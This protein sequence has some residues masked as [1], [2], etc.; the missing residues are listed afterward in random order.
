MTFLASARN[1]IHICEAASEEYLGAYVKSLSI[2]QD[3]IA[4]YVH[5]NQNSSLSIFRNKSFWYLGNLNL[6][7]PETHYRCVQPNGCNYGSEF[8]PSSEEGEWT[9]AVRHGQSPVPLISVN[10]CAVDNEL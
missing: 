6:W 3:G 8:P 2:L 9:V 10:P 7:P 5:S 4:V 1:E